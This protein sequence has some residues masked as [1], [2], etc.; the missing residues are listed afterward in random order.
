M[1]GFRR[2][3]TSDGQEAGEAVGAYALE[4]VPLGVGLGPLRRGVEHRVVV[5]RRH[6]LG[7]QVGA[8][9][10][11]QEEAVLAR[12]RDVEEVVVAAAPLLRDVGL[13]RADLRFRFARFTFRFVGVYRY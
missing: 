10:R 4:E 7:R 13:G 3:V 6:Q 12:L 1:R 2:Q 5:V 8:D 11:A 9:Q